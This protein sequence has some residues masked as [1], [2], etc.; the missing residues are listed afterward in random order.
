MDRS[1]PRNP[2]PNGKDKQPLGHSHLVST[3][4]GHILQILH[5]ECQ[6]RHVALL[7]RTVK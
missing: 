7:G 1:S 5:Y 4:Q 3:I 6:H 2:K